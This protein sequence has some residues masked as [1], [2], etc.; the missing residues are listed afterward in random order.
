MDL[1]NY[2]G[3]GAAVGKLPPYVKAAFQ[4]YRNYD[5]RGGTF[6]D[7]A[8][9]ATLADPSKASVFAATDSKRGGALTIVVI[10]KSQRAFYDAKLSI[11]AGAAQSSCQSA[12][13]F[14]M[15]APGAAVVA[16]PPVAVMNGTIAHRLPPLSATLF[17]CTK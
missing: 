12:H 13:V 16:L 14:V 9:R 10:N 1:A 2:W 8:V 6:G 5:G 4:L 17:A 7:T 15:Q 11:A 3:S